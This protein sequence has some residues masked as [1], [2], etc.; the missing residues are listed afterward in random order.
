[1]CHLIIMSLSSTTWTLLISPTSASLGVLPSSPGRWNNAL[2]IPSSS[3]LWSPM[4]PTKR[5]DSLSLS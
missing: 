1:M 3:H 5:Y 4:H 2:L